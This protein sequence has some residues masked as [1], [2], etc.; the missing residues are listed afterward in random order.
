VAKAFTL[1]DPILLKRQAT[2]QNPVQGI[3]GQ[4]PTAGRRHQTFQFK[5][6]RRLPWLNNADPIDARAGRTA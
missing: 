2:Q 3:D 5:P 4:P 1:S 6:Y